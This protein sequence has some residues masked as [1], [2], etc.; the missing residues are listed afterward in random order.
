MCA[1][2]VVSEALANAA[3]HSRAAA[4]TVTGGLADGDVLTGAGPRRRGR[5]ARLGAGTGLIG[6]QD[7]VEA[8]GGQFTL[9]SPLGQG[10]TDTAQLPITTDERHR[11]RKGKEG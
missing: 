8:L 1:Y 5:G 11:P 6:L 9:H 7:R 10:T 3:K 4:A 2:Y